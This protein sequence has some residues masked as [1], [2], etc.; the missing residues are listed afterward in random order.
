V[1]EQI[2]ELGL[3][4]ETALLPLIDRILSILPDA[5]GDSEKLQSGRFRE[6]IQRCREQLRGNGQVEPVA[7]RMLELCQDY[8][9]RAR[10]YRL[11]RELEYVEMIEVLRGAISKLVGDA[12]NFNAQLL[13]ST[14]RFDKLTEIDDIREIK[15]QIKREVQCIRVAMEEKQR[16]EEDNVSFLSQRVEMLQVKL[17]RAQDEAAT[18]PLTKL[19]NR[20]AF[21]RT[22]SRWIEEHSKSDRPFVLA[23]ADID[24]FKRI[25]DNHGHP[26]GDRVLVGAAQFLSESIRPTDFAARYGGE[27]FALL[28]SGMKLTPAESRMSQLVET[29]SRHQ[30]QYESGELQFTMSCGLAE[31]AL[32]DTVETLIQR[33]DEALYEA[34]RKGKNRVVS[35]RK[36]LLKS[37][38]GA[39]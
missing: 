16:Q 14:E 37:M 31:Y 20:G 19:A 22:L 13:T 4:Q 17:H 29:I 27:E 24:D 15:H 12:K 3:Q 1:G 7:R 30:F 28:L 36:S 2:I 11:E 21:D 10:V 33:A 34:K 18:D 25:N 38:F 39:K 9:R 8:F 26:V 32:G 5:A 35:R 6:E 23:L